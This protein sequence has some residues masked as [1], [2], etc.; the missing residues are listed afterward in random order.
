MRWMSWLLC[1][2]LLLVAPAAAG[3]GEY[4]AAVRLIRTEAGAH[5][6]IL[7]GE[8]H[9]TREV[10]DLAAALVSAFAAERPVLLGLEVSR[11]EHAA[12]RRYLDSDGGVRARAA[13]RSGPFWQVQGD[14]HD[15]RRN[16]ALLDLVEELRL[17]RATGH[18][19]AILPFDLPQ[20]AANGSEHRDAAMA[21]RVRAAH[22]ALPRGRLLVLAG[23]VHAMQCKPPRAP[24][25]MQTPMGWHLRDLDPYAV[26]IV[27]MTGHFW[28]CTS[29]C[30]AVNAMPGTAGNGPIRSGFLDGV[31]DLQVVLPAFSVARLI[32][33]PPPGR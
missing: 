20:H 28:A 4:D 7:L 17:L 1:L 30:R 9:G 16:H 11:E 18:D 33:A 3:A 26:N 19:V 14:Q 15:G 10:P 6:L 27:A 32:G 8:K 2:V 24:A 31:Y 22:A 25:Q 23:N 29:G 21:Q 13:L 5:R 12:M